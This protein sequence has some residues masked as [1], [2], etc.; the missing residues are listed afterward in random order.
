MIN[1]N[2]KLM[3]FSSFTNEEAEVLFL[4]TSGSFGN[5]DRVKI[6][7]NHQKKHLARWPF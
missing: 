7:F 1:A 3:V 2:T 5:N 4:E 6:N